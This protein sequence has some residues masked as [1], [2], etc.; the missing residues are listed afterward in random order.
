ML[1]KVFNDLFTGH[2]LPPV[3]EARVSQFPPKIWNSGTRVFTGGERCEFK[4]SRAH[5]SY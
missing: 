3:G 5:I 2:Y 1:V 4:R